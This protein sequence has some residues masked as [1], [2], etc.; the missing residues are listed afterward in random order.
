MEY[1]GLGRTNNNN[2]SSSST[3]N[4]SRSTRDKSPLQKERVPQV[5]LRSAFQAILWKEV[6]EVEPEKEDKEDKETAGLK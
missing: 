4:R 5:V 1:E 6:E 3:S 2:S